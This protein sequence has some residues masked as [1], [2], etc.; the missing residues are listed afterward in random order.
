MKAIYD[1]IL[2]SYQANEIAEDMNY[3]DN[4]ELTAEQQAAKTWFT[5]V[6]PDGTYTFE[7]MPTYHQWVCD[8]E[9]GWELYY[10]YG[11]SY[12]FAVN[13]NIEQNEE[14]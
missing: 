8:L 4:E 14:E 7:E 10:D 11:A 6:I 3:E 5:E 13:E 1:A 9:D 2:E 12:Y